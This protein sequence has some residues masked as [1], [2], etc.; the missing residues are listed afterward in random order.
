MLD[1]NVHIGG[2]IDEVNLR[3]VRDK[4]CEPQKDKIMIII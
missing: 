1:V 4:H 2:N 3:Y